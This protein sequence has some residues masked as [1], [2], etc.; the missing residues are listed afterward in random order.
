[1]KRVTFTNQL[2]DHAGIFLTCLVGYCRARMDGTGTTRRSGWSRLVPASLETAYRKDPA[3]RGVRGAE[4]ILYPGVWALWIHRLVHPLHCLGVPFL[5]RLI[6]QLARMLTGVEIHPGA[7]IGHRFFI[8]HA[9]GV[10]IGETS[11]IGDDVMMYHGVTLGGHGWW[12]DRKGSKRHP[13]IGDNVTLGVGAAV[14]GPVTVGANSRIGPYAVVI[15]DVPPN[16][17]VV[18]PKGR[19]LA[20]RG[21]PVDHGIRAG[22]G[23]G[24]G[25]DTG[26][27]SE[28]D[29]LLQPAWLEDHE[30][31]AL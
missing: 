26:N 20:E 25:N 9:A 6:S 29:G 27:G 31:G 13:T 23:T 30:M 19:R 5:P 1:M 15:E 16:S 2:L 28:V 21:V 7:T 24:I 10:V 11:E 22:D 18:A 8:D 14:L 4:A 17:I 12:A 3:L